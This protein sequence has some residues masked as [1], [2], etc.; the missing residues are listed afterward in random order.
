MNGKDLLNELEHLD[1]ALV[2]KHAKTVPARGTTRRIRWG[3]LAACLVLLAG[4][5]G[6]PILSSWWESQMETWES[7]METLSATVGGGAEEDEYATSGAAAVQLVAEAEYPELPQQPSEQAWMDGELTEEEFDEQNEAYYEAYDALQREQPDSAYLDGL[8]GFTGSTMEQIL[9]GEKVENVVYSPANLY[10]ALAMLSETAKGNSQ[11]QILDLLGVE[12]T[13]T[14]REQTGRIWKQLY[15]NGA[16]TKTLL[17]NSIWL[18]SELSFHADIVDRLAKDY[19]ASTY[20]AVMGD[21]E[22]E[23][24][25]AKW[26][27]ENTG[28]LLQKETQG[29]ELDKNT[30]MA[31]YSTLYF[32]DQWAI[33]FDENKTA[34]D[35]FTTAG[36]KEMQTDFMH[37][38]GH[39]A[40]VRGDGY[41]KASLYFSGATSMTFVMPDEGT[42][43]DQ[44]LGD[45]ETVATL[46]HTEEEQEEYGEIVWSIPK[47]DV[48][49]H[50]ALNK[51]LQAL[52]VSDI[53]HPGTANFTPLTEEQEAAI[54][55]IDQ[56]ARVKIDENGC[57]AASYTEIVMA[58]EADV[59]EELPS[60]TMNLNRPFLF[61]ISGTDNLPLFVGVVNQPGE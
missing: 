43:I 53:F 11:K 34:P 29:I 23:Q 40:F 12:D 8:Q 31:L 49:S 30:I 36:E 61:V 14:M 44:L 1:D 19:F 15:N 48:S 54:S 51:D 27:D 28:N 17:A 58:G 21:K 45:P 39:G 59:V 26:I 18:N 57:E 60:F 25:I 10:M 35:T 38:T 20:Q 55:R 42:T 32:Y 24:A 46:F 7:Q 4:I 56:A 22:T 3:A 2:Q 33:Q 50:R 47:F 5:G 6:G 52:G 41:S 16:Y 9:S 37:L 13:D